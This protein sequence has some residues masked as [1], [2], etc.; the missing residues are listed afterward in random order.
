MTVSSNLIINN[1]NPFEGEVSIP[2]NSVITLTFTSPAGET[3]EFKTTSMPT[4][5]NSKN[6]NDNNNDDL[7]STSEN[8][9]CGKVTETMVF[10][11][12][13][14]NVTG[15]YVIF[16]KPGGLAICEAEIYGTPKGNFIFIRNI[17]CCK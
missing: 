11:D 12:L 14:C 15:R 2:V 13:E 3:T 16:W 8:Y 9:F 1:S 5:S 6:I 7:G 10:Q 17:C 4:E